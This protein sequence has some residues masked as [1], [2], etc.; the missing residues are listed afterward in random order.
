MNQLGMLL[1]VI[2]GGLGMFLVVIALSFLATVIVT[3]GSDS[4]D[5]EKIIVDHEEFDDS[6]VANKE[7]IYIINTEEFFDR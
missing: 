6:E 1:T 7:D 2:L 5:M 3:K 4:S